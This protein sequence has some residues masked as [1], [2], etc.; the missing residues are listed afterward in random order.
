MSQHDH[1]LADQNGANFLSDINL[2]LGAIATNNSG[3]TEPAAP[4]SYQWW[5]DTGSTPPMLRQ[6]NASNTAWMPMIELGKLAASVD[7]QAFT[8][9]GTWTKPA[10]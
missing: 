4:Y 2:A 8:A 9:N 5:A 7:V 6:R 1:V 10:G 3:A